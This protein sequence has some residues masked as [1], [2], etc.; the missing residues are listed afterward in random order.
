MGKIAWRN[1]DGRKTVKLADGTAVKKNF[2][3]YYEIE[4]EM[5]GSAMRA[6]EYGGDKDYSWMM[7]APAAE[8]PHSAAVAEA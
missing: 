8:E 5:V 3:I 6:D 7:L 1:T 4:G 2:N